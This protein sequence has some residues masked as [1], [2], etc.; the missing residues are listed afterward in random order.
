[1]KKI[2]DDKRLMIRVCDLYYNK[3]LKQEEIAR[4]MEISRPTVS[5]I[6]SNARKEGIVKIEVVNPFQHNYFQ[7]ERELEDKYGLKEVIISDDYLDDAEGKYHLGQACAKYL[8]R[9]LADDEIV[10]ISM[11]RTIKQVSPHIKFEKFSNINF[12]PLLGGMGQVGIE[13]HCN[14]IVIDFARAFGGKFHLLHAPAYISDEDLMKSLKK[15][16]HISQVFDL[17]ENITTAVVGIGTEMEGS[18]MMES[19]YYN[20]EDIREFKSLGIVGDVCLQMYDINGNTD[21]PYNNHIFGYDI[22]NL[23]KI[24]RSIGVASGEE[25]IEAIYGAIKGGFVNVLVT[26]NLTARMLLDK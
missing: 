5:R 4:R 21:Y 26:D 25:K 11:G 2:F 23:R 20:R 6:I 22:K 14:Q 8:Q 13:Y 15:D 9:T 19:E 7:T 18:T 17:M 10:G 1:M 12:I 3:G 16:I 24:R